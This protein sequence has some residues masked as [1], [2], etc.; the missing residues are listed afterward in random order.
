M[1][2]QLKVDLVHSDNVIDAESV[3]ATNI[4]EEAVHPS[5]VDVPELSISDVDVTEEAVADEFA[6]LSLDDDLAND[7]A[8]P[9]TDDDAIMVVANDNQTDKEEEVA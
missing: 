5:I 6:I 2:T 7:A 1:Q 3:L 8:T 4:H 9:T